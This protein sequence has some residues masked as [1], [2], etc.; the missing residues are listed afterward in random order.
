[1]E[2]TNFIN[3]IQD[4]CNLLAPV[5][6]P[7]MKNFVVCRCFKLCQTSELDTQDNC[8]SW[9]F[10]CCLLVRLL[11]SSLLYRRLVIQSCLQVIWWP[12]ASMVSWW[13][14]S[15]IIGMLKSHMSKQTSFVTLH[16]LED[17]IYIEIVLSLVFGGILVLK[18]A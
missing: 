11:V 15:C 2:D 16:Y 12:H 10:S 8:H 18:K 14:K 17:H 6:F 3:F 5:V 9:W 1:M 13:H 7:L 4:F